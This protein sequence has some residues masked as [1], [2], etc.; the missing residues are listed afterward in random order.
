[1][2]N[3]KISA[4]EAEENLRKNPVNVFKCSC[5]KAKEFTPDELKKHLSEV[6]NIEAIKG[7]KQMVSHMDGSYWFSSTYKWTL[8]SGLVFHQYCEM[9]RSKNDMMRY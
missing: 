1:M 7:T 4:K 8:E 9:A 5:D 3:K 6:H 2:A